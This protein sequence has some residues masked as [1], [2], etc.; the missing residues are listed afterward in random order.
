MRSAT[1]CGELEE[2]VVVESTACFTYT[3][4]RT[5]M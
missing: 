4:V 5:K 3:F 2:E 1:N